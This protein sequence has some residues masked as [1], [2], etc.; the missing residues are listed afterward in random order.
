VTVGATRLEAFRSRL[1]G[2]LVLTDFDGTLAP[3]VARPEDAR[4][5]P[6]AAAVLAGL[7]PRV[8]GVA[9]VTGRPSAVVR[10]LLPVDGVHV[11]G[12]YGFEDA[13]PMP[14]DALAAG[15]EVAEGEPGAQLEPKGPSA[16]VHFRN[17][18]DPE[19]AGERL[20]DALAAVADAF[21]LRL[22]E[23]KRVWELA[24]RG[25]GGKGEAVAA[26]LDR[27]SPAA[28]LFAGDDV[29]DLEAFTALDRFAATGSGAVTVKVAVLG[30]ETPVALR[31]GADVIVGSP[32]EFLELLRGL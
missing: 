22:L 13:P 6:D 32:A 20:R 25:V 3:I 5:L 12:L 18:P 10:R 28:A 24:P 30:P 11:A 29:A 14:A 15:R 23:G 8:L 7:A 9:I 31:E 27:F 21:G 2:A 1:G 4:P 16:A 19:A 26:L 17:A